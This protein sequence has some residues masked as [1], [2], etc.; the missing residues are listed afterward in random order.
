MATCAECKVNVGCGCKLNKYG[1]CAS[2]AIAQQEIV[3]KQKK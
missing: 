2:C 1:L 3:D